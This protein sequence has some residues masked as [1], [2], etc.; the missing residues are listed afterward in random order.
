M[1]CTEYELI[2]HGDEIAYCLQVVFVSCLLPHGYLIGV[3]K[4]E[5]VEQI[6]VGLLLCNL[7]CIVVGR[8]T[9]GDIAVV[10]LHERDKQTAIVAEHQINFARVHFIV[11]VDGAHSVLDFGL[12]IGVLLNEQLCH[13]GDELRLCKLPVQNDDFVALAATAGK[14][15]GEQ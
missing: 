11:A 15:T 13:F 6:D 9:L 4:T 10:F 12:E 1:L 8:H 2:R 14:H 7:V 3:V 5:L